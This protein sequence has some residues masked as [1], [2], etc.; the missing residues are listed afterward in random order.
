MNTYLKFSKV[1]L[2]NIPFPAALLFVLLATCAAPDPGGQASVVRPAN[3]GPLESQAILSADEIARKLKY[4]PSAG[5]SS[6]ESASQTYGQLQEYFT[7]GESSIEFDHSLPPKQERPEKARF[8]ALED[9]DC[10]EINSYLLILWEELVL[11][12][13]PSLLLESGLK[14]I[15]LTDSITYSSELHS[16]FIDL[17]TGTLYLGIREGYLYVSLTLQDARD[18]FDSYRRHV[19][20]H[21]IFGFVGQGH[22]DSAHEN[23]SEWLSLNPAGFRYRDLEWS[24]DQY[25]YTFNLFSPSKK[26]QHQLHQ[27]E[28]ECRPEEGFVTPYAKTSVAE[29][30]GEIFALLMSRDPRCPTLGLRDGDPIIKAKIDLLVSQYPFL[31]SKN[32]S[33]FEKTMLVWHNGIRSRVSSN[34][35]RNRFDSDIDLPI[36]DP[37]LSPLRWS[38]QLAFHARE[39]LEDCPDQGGGLAGD[40]MDVNFIDSPGPNSTGTIGIISLVSNIWGLTSYEYF[41]EKNDAEDC[42]PHKRVLMRDTFLMGCAKK[43]CEVTQPSEGFRSAEDLQRL[44]ISCFYFPAGDVSGEPY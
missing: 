35:I 10:E 21:G 15:I 41:R 6:C 20:H 38:P 42:Y 39:Y 30:K 27:S 44:I 19:L 43:E 8:T 9:D 5:V 25:M 26:F 17:K 28:F 4:Q 16:S 32:L 22:S 33:E 18:F 11:Q 23:D 34:Y 36:A 37:P 7:D 1:Q 12:Y 40:D 31:A 29:D 3:H 13:E 14:R 2:H 24:E